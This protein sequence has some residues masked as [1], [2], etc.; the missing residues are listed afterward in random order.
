M[1]VRVFPRGLP[2]SQSESGEGLDRL[3][4]VEYTNRGL[5]CRRAH[6]A[7]LLIIGVGLMLAANVIV[8]PAIPGLVDP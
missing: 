6:T 7:Q 3:K 5:W 1:Q 2:L 4:A 8:L